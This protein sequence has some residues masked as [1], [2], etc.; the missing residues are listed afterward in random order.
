MRQ[1]GL[2]V[3]PALSFFAAPFVVEPQLAGKAYRIGVLN[4]GIAGRPVVNEPSPTFRRGSDTSLRRRTLTS[5][6]VYDQH[7]SKA[8]LPGHHLR[9][10]GCG[11]L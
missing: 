8:R 2:A 4:A 6:V 7:H 1:I 10:G 5:T 11:F 9:V 3:V